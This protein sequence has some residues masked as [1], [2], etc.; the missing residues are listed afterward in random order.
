MTCQQD[1]LRAAMVE[2]NMT[3]DKFCEQL[4]C[5]KRTLDKWLL[6]VTSN[7]HRTL[8]ETIW[9]LV[10]EILTHESLKT[11]LKKSKESKYH[12]LYIPIGDIR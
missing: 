2:L 5:V 9:V 6:P 8:D 12:L 11:S 7:D 4:G 10:R 1:F 3:R